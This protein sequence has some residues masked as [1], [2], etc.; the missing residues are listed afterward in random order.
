MHRYILCLIAALVSSGSWAFRYEIVGTVADS[1]YH[2][3]KLG[4]YDVSIPK[5]GN[6][7]VEIDSCVCS[8]EGNFRF[9]GEYDFDN[10]AVIG[11]AYEIPGGM[12]IDYI[13]T[14]AMAQGETLMDMAELAPL[15]GSLENQK[16]RELIVGINRCMRALQSKDMSL[17]QFRTEVAD[18]C[19]GILKDNTDNATGRYALYYL[20]YCIDNKDWYEIYKS[21]SPYLRRHAPAEELAQRLEIQFNAETDKPYIDIK[22]LDSESKEI[23]ISDIVEKGRPTIV[24]FWASWCR[25]CMEEIKSTIWPLYEKYG[26]DGMINIIGIGV[27]DK[28]ENLLAAVGRLGMEWPQIVDPHVS[29]TKVY[30]FNAIPFILVINS[31]GTIVARG[32]RGEALVS[33][34]DSLVASEE[35]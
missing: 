3:K 23:S 13:G 10:L 14:L 9:S 16:L 6:Q 8:P 28:P 27:N 7:Y 26:K 29:P 19:R 1:L 22:G 17:D 24:D 2:G 34:I 15:S 4:L 11:A 30:G 25:P 18:M 20:S 32:I 31:E 21:S 5:Q 12:R 33:L 35:K